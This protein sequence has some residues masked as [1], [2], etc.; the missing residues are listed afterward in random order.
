M[1][2][3]CATQSHATAIFRSRKPEYIS[4][5][6]KQGHVVRGIDLAVLSVKM[7]CCHDE[8]SV[9]R[10]IGMGY[11]ICEYRGFLISVISAAKTATSKRSNPELELRR[12]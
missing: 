6:P 1:H 3:A 4:N 7:D 12:D 11:R 5:R 9:L 2:R 8:A 10:L